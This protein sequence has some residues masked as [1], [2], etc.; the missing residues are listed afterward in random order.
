MLVTV[1]AVDSV[2]SSI[3]GSC[4]S[5]QT[6]SGSVKIPVPREGPGIPMTI[7]LVRAITESQRLRYRQAL[8]A[9]QE[10]Q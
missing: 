5:D 2:Q 1:S 4:T 10:I 8:K 7:N 3:V 6:G 9:L